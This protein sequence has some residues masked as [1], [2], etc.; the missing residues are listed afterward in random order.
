MVAPKPY[1]LEEP[2]DFTDRKADLHYDWNME[3]MVWM[4]YWE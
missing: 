4:I 3:A 2:A 1:L